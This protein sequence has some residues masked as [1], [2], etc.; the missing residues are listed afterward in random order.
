MSVRDERREMRDWQLRVVS[1]F[2]KREKRFDRQ[3]RPADV[4]MCRFNQQ[5]VRVVRVNETCKRSTLGIYLILGTGG[6]L[7]EKR[8]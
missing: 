6:Y 3:L 1:A 7:S 8:A 2:I 4:Q 5:K